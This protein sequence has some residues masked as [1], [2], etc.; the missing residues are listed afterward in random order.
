MSKP[1]EFIKK[2][3]KATR[4]A[5]KDE[6]KEIKY[7]EPTEED[8]EQARRLA[9]LCAAAMV[10]GGLPMGVLATKVLERVLAYGIRDLKDGVADR[11][12]LIIER[13]FTELR[14]EE[15]GT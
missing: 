10:A 7:L 8:Y 1:V 13:V 14:A 11:K 6:I 15:L 5:V 12:K 2:L 9:A 3:F 4:V